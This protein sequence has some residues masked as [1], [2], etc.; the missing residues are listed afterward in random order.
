MLATQKDRASRLK[1]ANLLSRATRTSGRGTNRRR[2]E[3]KSVPPSRKGL[4]E[5]KKGMTY[6]TSS[7]MIDKEPGSIRWVTSRVIRKGSLEERSRG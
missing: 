1:E 3:E 7:G 4:S 2:P 6:F 5:E